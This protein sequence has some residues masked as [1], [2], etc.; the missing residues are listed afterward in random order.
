MK[1]IWTFFFLCICALSVA[2][3]TGAVKPPSGIGPGKREN[4]SE[5]ADLKILSKPNAPYPIG[6][7]CVQG[8]VRLKVEFLKTGK[9]GKIVPVTRLPHGLTESAIKAAG[10]IRFRPKRVAGKN[11]T[12][13]DTVVYTF[14]IY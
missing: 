1:P 12:V 5:N 11:A 10:K 3:Q 13:V 7:I 9:I 8:T 14:S 6:T 4:L 2:A